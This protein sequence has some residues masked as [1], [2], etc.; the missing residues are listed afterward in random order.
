MPDCADTC[1]ALA[2]VLYQKKQYEE[3]ASLYQQA[4]SAD[5]EYAQAHFGLAKVYLQWK[6]YIDSSAEMDKALGQRP[7]LIKP[8]MNLGVRFLQEGK[9]DEAVAVFTKILNH[10]P[11]DIQALM[12]LGRAYMRMGKYEDA[13]S[14]ILQVLERSPELAEA[15][16][17]QGNIYEY[18]RQH[19]EALLCYENASGFDPDL[20]PAWFSLARVQ[21]KLGNYDKALDAYQ[22]I[23]ALKSD[24]IDA[25]IAQVNLLGIKGDFAAAEELLQPLVLKEESNIHIA[26]MLTRHCIHT[27]NYQHG[28]SYLE[29]LIYQNNVADA[30]KAKAH[31]YLGSLYD[32]LQMFDMA[33]EHFTTGNALKKTDLTIDLFSRFIDGIITEHSPESYKGLPRASSAYSR[34][35]F[36]IGMPRSG[37]TLVEKILTNH[38]DVYGGG[39]LRIIPLMV[40]DLHKKLGIIVQYPMCISHITKQLVDELADEYVKQ[41]DQLS[42]EAR[43]TTDR[44]PHNFLNLGLISLMFPNAQ[45]VHCRR[46]PVDNCLTCFFQGFS[47]DHPYV[48]DLVDLGKFYRNYDRLMSHW[49][50]TLQIP[51]LEINYEDLV[52]DTM[53]SARLLMDYCDLEWDDQ[54]MKLLT[55]VTNGRATNNSATRWKNYEKHLTPLRT[56][57]GIQ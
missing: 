44:L 46:D 34:P 17:L 6:M 14:R 13:R 28:I 7:G 19:E 11:A 15:H 36:I 49:T 42:M 32:G 25:A 16:L 41:L 1:V 21:E 39:E 2:N 4:I 26:D 12:N 47:G 24:S 5:S 48:H 18:R 31:I 3:S 45:I 22:H 52:L 53:K 23:Q 38:P 37:A 50:E 33:F 8:F 40:N 9:L 29:K 51:M 20:L 30:E 35:I 57:L 27:K 55:T 43:F 10:E 56:A 54:R